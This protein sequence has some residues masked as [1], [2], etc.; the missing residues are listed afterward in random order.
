M[1]PWRDRDETERVLQQARRMQAELLSTA[2]L[3]EEF[4]SALNEATDEIVQDIEEQ[5]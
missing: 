4:V 5:R 1:T 3:L 2:R